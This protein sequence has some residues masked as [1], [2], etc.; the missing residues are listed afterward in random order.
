M[1]LS[2][3]LS[4]CYSAWQIKLARVVRKLKTLLEESHM[5]D[6]RLLEGRKEAVLNPL[7]A[8]IVEMGLGRYFSYCKKQLICAP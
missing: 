2:I 1:L 4:T 6:P 8:Y 7:K 3:S 5:P